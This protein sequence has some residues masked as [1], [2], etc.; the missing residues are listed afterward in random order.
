MRF[1]NQAKQIFVLSLYTYI[2]IFEPDIHPPIPSA[3]YPWDR[4]MNNEQQLALAR[5]YAKTVATSD[6]LEFNELTLS[7]SSSHFSVSTHQNHSHQIVTVLLI[8]DS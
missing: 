6:T 1:F 2:Q 3:I 5:F 8:T 7:Q 4:Q